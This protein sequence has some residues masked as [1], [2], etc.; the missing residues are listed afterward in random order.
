[1]PVF[2]ARNSTDNVQSMLQGAM[3][4]H[5]LFKTTTRRES[6][7]PWINRMV[8]KFIQKRRR[9]YDREGKRESRKWKR[10]KILSDKMRELTVKKPT[11]FD[12]RD[13]ESFQGKSDEELSHGQSFLLRY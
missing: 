5:F 8:R 2:V 6:D 1:M 12:V 13:L 3:D 4:I 9:V 11:T 7:P 10:L